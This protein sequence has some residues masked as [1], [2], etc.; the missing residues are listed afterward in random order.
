MAA[1]PV[2]SYDYRI[3]PHCNQKKVVML[4]MK[5]KEIDIPIFSISKLR[6]K[7]CHSEF[8]PRWIPGDKEGELVMVAGSFDEQSEVT[9]EIIDLVSKNERKLV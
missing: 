1:I 3:C 5:G 2:S 4:D 6:C 8:F 7:A 9:Q